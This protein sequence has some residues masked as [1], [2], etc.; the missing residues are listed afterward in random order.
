M[1]FNTPRREIIDL[2]PN[3]RSPNT[4]AGDRRAALVHL[5]QHHLE[6]GFRQV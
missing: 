6:I 1:P 3:K 4:R 5:A 2:L